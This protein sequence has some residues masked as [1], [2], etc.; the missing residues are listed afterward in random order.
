MR[1]RR[2]FTMIEMIVTV[3][4][5][6]LTGTAV[7]RLMMGQARFY[8][9]QRAGREARVVSRSALNALLSELRMIEARGGVVAAT[10]TSI[11]FR[12]PYAVG[13]LCR[14]T[15]GVT[16][17]SFLPTDSAR[18]DETGFSGYGWRNGAG[19]YSYVDAGVTLGSGLTSD[20]AAANITTLSGGRV[21]GI[22]PAL[23]T[24]ATSASAVMLF[25]RITYRFAN[26]ASMPGRVALWRRVETT[27]SEEEL[28][29]PFESTAQFRF[30]ALNANTAQDAVP[31]LADIRGIEVVLAGS[32]ERVPQGETGFQRASS[33][34]AIFFRN[35]L[36]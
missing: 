34:T 4:L 5:L 28:V 32:S 27:G 21:A 33:T 23:P 6:A 2:G 8:E 1:E 36:E 14:T 29:A 26:S 13:L 30:Y 10:S 12:V 19:V 25:R 31:T 9:K 11:T 20:C 16:T 15:G 3:L 7:L 22:S 35:R 17:V 18:Y 24:T